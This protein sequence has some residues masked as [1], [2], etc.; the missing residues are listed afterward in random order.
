MNT[1]LASA[2]ALL[3][4]AAAA[5]P[6]LYVDNYAG[7][8]RGE[9]WPATLGWFNFG[10]GLRIVGPVANASLVAPGDALLGDSH[11]GGLVAQVPAANPAAAGTASQTPA[12][13]L[14]LRA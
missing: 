11:A 3:S 14:R 13:A 6:V 12:R 5:Q 7:R 1:R 10:D 4:L 9:G 8:F 2:A